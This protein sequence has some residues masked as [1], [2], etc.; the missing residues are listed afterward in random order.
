MMDKV[1]QR[2][3]A[4]QPYKPGKPIDELARELGINDIVKLASNENPLGPGQDVL[5]AISEASQQLPRYPDGSGYELKQALATQL[6]VDTAQI[7]LGNGSN[8]VL[9]LIARVAMQPGDEAIIAEHS[10]V[11]YRLAVTCCGGDL[12]TVPAKDFGADL[13]AMLAAVNER[14]RLVFLANP[15]NPTGT[16]VTAAA[17][18]N[19]L[20]QVP[21]DVW[22]VLDEAY[23]EYVEEAEYGNGLDLLSKHPNLIVTRTFSKIYGLA[24]VRLGFSVSSPEFA[25]LLNRA[26]QPFNVNGLAMAAGLAA[27]ADDDYVQRSRALNREGMRQITDGLAA[28]GYSYIPS[29]GNFVAFDS[30]RPGAE[31][32]EQ[33]LQQGVIVRPIAEYGLPNHVRVSIGLPIENERFLT[34]LATIGQN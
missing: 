27:L 26:R 21:A 34:A 33:L 13:D 11:V 7:T 19:F 32:F 18:E 10:F 22:V 31:V 2:I 6:E 12:V 30:G 29:V 15:N 23:F 3:A 1:N 16:W 24:S 4:L 9:D 17:V 14:T 5:D 8:D 28:L 20:Q 25:D